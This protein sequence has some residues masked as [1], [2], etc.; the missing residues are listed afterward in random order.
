MHILKMTL[1]I[2]TLVG[3][4]AIYEKVTGNYDDLSPVT[5]V[6]TGEKPFGKSSSPAPSS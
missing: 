3:I 1:A 5:L 2:I 4:V 6:L